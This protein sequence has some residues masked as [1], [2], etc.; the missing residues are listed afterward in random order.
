M[1]YKTYTENNDSK[2]DGKKDSK[3]DNKELTSLIEDENANVMNPPLRTLIKFLLLIIEFKLIS[4][5]EN[6]FKDIISQ[7]INL[8]ALDISP[9]FQK[10]V[11][12]ILQNYL[13]NDKIKP[14]FKNN[15]ILHICSSQL[16]DVILYMYSVS[17]IDVR[18]E[19][20]LLLKELVCKYGEFL[21]KKNI[22]IQNKIISF[23]SI[24]FLP[25]N[26]LA[27]QEKSVCVTKKIKF[28]VIKDKEKKPKQQSSKNLTRLSYTKY[29]VS[30]LFIQNLNIEIYELS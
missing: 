13:N 28:E 8:L 16:I 25:N 3:K 15:I 30:L 14:E 1:F 19:C 12:E 18:C 5:T 20:L 6:N 23:L 24:C 21:K 10:A 7:F 11:I 2:K 29:P 17:L 26:L 4:L 27:L 9:C 22:K